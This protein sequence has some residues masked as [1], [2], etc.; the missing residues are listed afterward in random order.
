M[1]ETLKRFL[2][3]NAYQLIVAVITIVLT[4]IAAYVSLQL[5]QQ[6]TTLQIQAMQRDIA[7]LQANSVDRGELKPINDKLTDIKN[8]VSQILGVLLNK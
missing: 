8:D 7:V 6:S 5:F 1:N 3:A 2:Q 4:F